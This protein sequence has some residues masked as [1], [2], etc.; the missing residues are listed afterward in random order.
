MGTYLANPLIPLYESPTIH[1]E[2]PI[3]DALIAVRRDAADP[4]SRLSLPLYASAGVGARVE[5]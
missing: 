4:N 2:L 3:R 5:R 1:P